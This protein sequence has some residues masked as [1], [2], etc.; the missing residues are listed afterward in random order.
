MDHEDDIEHD[1]WRSCCGIILQR[2]CIQYTIHVLFSIAISSFCIGK[3]TLQS[4]DI[5]PLE[6]AHDQTLY[7]SI[8]LFIFGTLTNGT[9]L[10]HIRTY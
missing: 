8:V 7:I 3:L 2:Q 6:K 10:Q 5:D 9:H 1:R 4:Q